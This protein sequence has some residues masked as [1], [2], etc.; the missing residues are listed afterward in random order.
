MKGDIRYVPIPLRLR[1]ALIDIAVIALAFFVAAMLL[2]STSLPG[3]LKFILMAG[4]LFMLEPGLVAF[5]GATPGQHVMGI[6]VVSASSGGRIGVARATLRFLA[7]AF[8][9]I[10]SLIFILVTS[11]YQAL[12]DIMLRTLVTDR[13]PAT[14]DY[15]PLTS[16]NVVEETGYI[17]PPKWRRVVAIVIYYVMVLALS[18]LVQLATLSE[19]CIV[20]NAC[21]TG[22]RLVLAASN[23]AELAGLLCCIVFG[24]KGYFWGARRRPL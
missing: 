6:Q 19:R 10:P 8:F 4:T 23:L 14:R 16:V 21:E 22:D 20:S 24:W 17:Y 18:G 7:K 1:A 3:T 15:D 12:H 11:R 13:R 5:S 2:S 9:G